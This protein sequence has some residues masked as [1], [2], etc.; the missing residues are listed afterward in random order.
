MYR[1]FPYYNILLL[2]VHKK[3]TF[4][5]YGKQIFV[6]SITLRFSIIISTFLSNLCNKLDNSI[7]LIK[8]EHAHI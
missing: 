1:F 3:L 4:N 2:C 6:S 8:S 5:A 7:Q